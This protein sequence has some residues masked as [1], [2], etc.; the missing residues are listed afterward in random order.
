MHYDPNGWP[1]VGKYV[2]SLVD[3]YFLS[4]HTIIKYESDWQSRHVYQDELD[5]F[6]AQVNNEIAPSPTR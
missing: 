2:G 1:C 6:N 4:L 3:W 5:C